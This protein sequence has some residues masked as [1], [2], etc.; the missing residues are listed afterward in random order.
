MNTVDALVHQ[1]DARTLTYRE[2]RAL[3]Q[4]ETDS[5]LESEMLDLEIEATELD[6]S[7]EA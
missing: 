4:L 1:I 5:L 7:E 6:P 3:G 2:L